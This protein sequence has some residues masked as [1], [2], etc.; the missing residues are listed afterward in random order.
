MK[1]NRFVL[2]FLLIAG[3]A[4]FSSA[5]PAAAQD[6]SE[7]LQHILE[8]G[9]SRQA[10]LTADDVRVYLKN[11][12]QI[13][14]LRFEPG[15]QAD[16]VREIN[17]WDENRFAYVTTK[18]AVGMSLLLRPDDARN[19]SVPNFTRPTAA[20]MTL[21]KTYQ[22]ELAKAMES[23]QTKYAGVVYPENRF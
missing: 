5:G 8:R 2:I 19:K 14:R 12:E 21:I 7:S 3:L 15:R 6:D 16:V 4:M 11:V 18:M 20:E 10:P 13:Y 9:M 23:M 22:D 17:Y 1:N